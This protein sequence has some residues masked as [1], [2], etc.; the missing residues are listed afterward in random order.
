MKDDKKTSIIKEALTDYNDIIEAADANA[1]KRLAD[2]FPDKFNSILNEEITKNK[3]KAKESYKKIKDDAEESDKDDEITNKES[4]MDKQVKETVKVVN[5]VGKGEPFKEKAKNVEETVT[6]KDTV[7]KSDPFNK[8]KID[9]EENVEETVTI[10][11]T[12]GKSDPFGKKK[13]DG[14][15][16]PTKIEEAFD[17][18]ELDIRGVEGALDTADDDDTISFDEI[19]EELASLEGLEEELNGMNGLPR[20]NSNF[21][22]P[23][24]QGGDVYVQK[25]KEM[26]NQIDEI[27][28]GMSNDGA[29]E[30]GL[31]TEELGLQSDEMSP[32]EFSSNSMEE[33]MYEIEISDDVITDDDIDA[34]LRAPENDVEEAY[35]VSYAANKVSSAN[36]PRPE[37]ASSSAAAERRRPAFVQEN[38]K[39]NALIEQ[40]KELTKKVNEAR[41]FKKSAVSLV[42]NY[43]TALEKY[44]N[45]LKEMAIFNTNL[46]NVNNLLVN[47]S[48]ALTQGDKIKIINEFKKV[49]TIAESQN[50]YKSFL[51]EMKEGKKTITESIEHKVSTSI[52]PSSKQL[53]DEVIEKTAYAN[54]KHINEMK[55]L[56]EYV[57]NRGKK[58]IK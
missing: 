41:K 9:E 31:Q 8:K 14:K 13:V 18:S 42:E 50:K 58:I 56:I 37:Y 23:T 49:N 7:G 48:L 22:T 32:E 51:T 52:Q 5:T 47:E 28:V 21:G 30:Q 6:I 35:G 10:Q 39:V 54:D 26:R 25:L 55:R 20:P 29:E 40:N 1:K 4:D 3:N 24:G 12:I 38:K 19:E 44:R 33:P 15:T 57:E 11:K 2:E 27:L 43:K 34:V 53:H 36:N 46:A 17:I 16:K 45:Q